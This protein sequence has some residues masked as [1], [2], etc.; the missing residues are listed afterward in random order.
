MLAR[1]IYA[2]HLI[3]ALVG[4]AALLEGMVRGHSGG[5]ILGC[6]GLAVFVSGRFLLRR[7]GQLEE[8]E[9]SFNA[10]GEG[11]AALREEAAELEEL[12]A[13]RDKLELLRGTSD[14]DP[15]ASMLLRR[16]IAER[17]RK[18][19]ELEPLLEIRD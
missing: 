8:C 4:L 13:R 11:R 14:F 15:W 12:M 5:W 6:A 17:V 9:R 19:P 3:A 1:T 16:E 2:M 18:N 10:L 7:S